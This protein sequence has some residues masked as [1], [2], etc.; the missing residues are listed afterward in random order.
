MKMVN[1]YIEELAGGNPNKAMIYTLKSGVKND[2]TLV[3]LQVNHYISCG[4]YAGY[5]PSGSLGGATSRR[6][7]LQDSQRPHRFGERLHE[8]AA[9][10]DHA[11]PRRAPGRIR[12]RVAIS[13]R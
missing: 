2:G 7:P 4:A 12:H 3:A 9:G 5:T 11:R 1:D 10:P 13:T 8:H 6:R